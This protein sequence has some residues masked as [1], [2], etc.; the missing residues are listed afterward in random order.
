M[1]F[2]NSLLII[3]RKTVAVYCEDKNER[4]NAIFER[5]EEVLS[6]D[7]C[8][9]QTGTCW[10]RSGVDSILRAVGM[11]YVQLHVAEPFLQI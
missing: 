2:V 8:E 5:K 4:H 11:T 3:F 6:V 1:S 10:G 9:T 7:S